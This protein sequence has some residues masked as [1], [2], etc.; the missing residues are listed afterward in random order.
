MLHF[1]ALDL[2]FD[3]HK[4]YAGLGLI[5]VRM[6]GKG[7]G[8]DDQG[9]VMEGGTS[10]APEPGGSLAADEQRFRWV[11]DGWGREG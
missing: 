5:D 11:E 6:R 7:G 2:S 8:K 4:A 10:Q 9:I 1:R 3:S